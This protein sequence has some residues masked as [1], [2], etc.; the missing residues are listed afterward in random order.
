MT[1]VDPTASFESNFKAWFATNVRASKVC[2][3]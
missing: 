2:D 1:G 3:V